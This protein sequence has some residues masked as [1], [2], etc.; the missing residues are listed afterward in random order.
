MANRNYLHE[1]TPS[2]SV[3]GSSRNGSPPPALSSSWSVPATVSHAA[4]ALGGLLRRFSTDPPKNHT[5]NTSPFTNSKGNGTN[6]VYTPPYRTASPFQPPP[7]YPIALKGWNESTPE[8]A[9]L[10]TKALAEEIRLLVPARLQLCEEWNLVYSLEENG[11]SLGTLYKKCD[12]LRGLRN[13]FCLVVRDGEGGVCLLSFS[14]LTSPRAQS[15]HVLTDN[16]C[17]ALWSLPNRCPSPFSSLLRHGRMLPLARLYLLPSQP[18]KPP[19]SSSFNRYNEPTTQHHNRLLDL[20]PP[21]KPKPKPQPQPF[22]LLPPLANTSILLHDHSIP[23]TLNTLSSSTISRLSLR[24]VNPRTNT[25]QGVS[26]QR[27]KRLPHTLRPVFPLR[28][29]R[30]RTLWVMARRYI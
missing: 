26:I 3:S 19:P 10:L 11:V 24:R 18:R 2:T 9:R 28:R 8:S 22:I 25:I 23:N 6:G 17:T 27:R 29:R 5:G 1:G 12:E 16:G 14:P 21:L 15:E 20:L 4:G 7:L 30:R 13:G